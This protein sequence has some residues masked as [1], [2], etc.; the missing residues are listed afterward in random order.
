M[1][2]NPNYET[3]IDFK[4]LFYHV[5]ARWRSIIVV[6]F[7]SAIALCGYR[8]LKTRDTA[9]NREAYEKEMIKYER[10]VDAYERYEDMIET[11]KAQ[12][13]ELTEYKEKSTKMKIDARNEWYARC[14]YFVELDKSVMDDLPT[15][16]TQDPADDLI[17][18]Y[19]SLFYDTAFDSEAEK[20][21]GVGE[22]K[23]V[24]EL[25]TWTISTAT[26]S[27][28]ISVIGTDE[29]QVKTMLD[30][31]MGKIEGSINEKINSEVKHKLTGANNMAYMRIDSELV[32]YQKSVD[33]RIISLRN[34]VSR[35]NT[36]K[37]AL[38][39]PV[40]P[41]DI[42]QHRG[43]AKYA[44]IGLV[45]GVAVA[46]CVYAVRYT[47]NGKL[48]CDDELQMLYDIPI[49]GIVSN[50]ITRKPGKGIDK[51]IEKARNRRIKTDR[52]IIYGQMAS[53]ISKNYDSKKVLIV[54][55]SSS[56]EV[57]SLYDALKNITGNRI[58][59][60]LEQDFLAK[61]ESLEEACKADAV[62]VAEVRDCSN[63]DEIERMGDMLSIAGCD[64]SGCVIL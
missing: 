38:T 24:N 34:S 46:V 59:L 8:F 56:E 42:T 11:Y 27:F 13:E 51:L 30:Y 43:F 52:D 62:L 50:S 53:M 37:A 44:V 31:Y 2:K 7:L 23:Y 64:V 49:Y 14:D 19:Q 4:D 28:T 25:V 58:S 26:N 29:Q 17:A 54:S 22:T 15:L 35:A 20:L 63:M 16:V 40:E 39:E 57:K 9:A 60:R 61:K 32:E 1:K 33:D 48:R 41:V 36:D 5:L 45:A 12:I 10:D 55:T 47:M 18:L 3:E 21:A 6:A